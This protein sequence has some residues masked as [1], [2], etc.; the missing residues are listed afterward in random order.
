MRSNGHNQTS[1]Q[2]LRSYVKNHSLMLSLLL[3]AYGAVYLTSVVLGGWTLADWGKDVTGY[4]PPSITPLLPRSFINPIFFVTSFPAL[5]IGTA[6]L[7]IYSIRG[8]SPQ[9]L[10]HKE[11]VGI[12]LTVC[13]FVYVVVGA[14]PLGVLVNFPWEWQKQI[15]RNG[16]A[17]AWSLYLLSLVALFVG[18]ASVYIHS[19]I[20]HQK[21]PE[22]ALENKIGS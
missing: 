16:T 18:G 11:H 12:L 3:A 20:Y 13:G 1:G 4:P 2:R 10:D 21:H 6:A 17:F 14:W 9:T 19:R 15:L 5:F 22:F 8:I 7:C